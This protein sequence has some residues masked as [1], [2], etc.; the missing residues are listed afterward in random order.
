MVSDVDEEVE[1]GKKVSADDW[2]G[3]VNH[4]KVS[5]V[6]AASEREPHGFVAV[7]QDS[8]TVGSHKVNVGASATSAVYLGFWKEGPAGI[9][10]DEEANT[11]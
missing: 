9:C 11:C 10:V 8:R 2:N 5:L 1:V 4:Y 7:R 6:G 3:D